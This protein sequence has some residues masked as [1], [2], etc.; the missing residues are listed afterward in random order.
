MAAKFPTLSQTVPEIAVWL[1]AWKERL[2]GG[3][4]GIA[5]APSARPPARALITPG[6]ALCTVRPPGARPLSIWP[7]FRQ[8]PQCT[9]DVLH[10]FLKTPNS[11]YMYGATAAPLPSALLPVPVPAC[12]PKAWPMRAGDGSTL[13][14][15]A[16]M[17]F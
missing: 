5:A 3:G 6:Q 11:I 12:P 17:G 9:S 2:R 13:G 1:G 16:S 8:S 10:S 4:G 15:P 14:L 7:A